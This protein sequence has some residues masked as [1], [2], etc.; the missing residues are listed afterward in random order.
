MRSE[1][2]FNL[3]LEMIYRLSSRPRLLR[4]PTTPSEPETPH[5]MLHRVVFHTHAMVMQTV[6]LPQLVFFNDQGTQLPSSD[7]KERLMRALVYNRIIKNKVERV[8]PTPAS[9]WTTGV[10]LRSGLIKLAVT[11]SGGGMTP[12]GMMI[13]MFL[14]QMSYFTLF[15]FFQSR[16]AIGTAPHLPQSAV[17]GQWKLSMTG[18]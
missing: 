12:T 15:L 14:F 6:G 18:V 5:I 16:P 8:M 1:H 17:G 4:S 10:P 2:S 3:R 9:T 11:P 7:P 13:G